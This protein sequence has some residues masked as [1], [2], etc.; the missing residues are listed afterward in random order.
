MSCSVLTVM[1]FLHT[2]RTSVY[3]RHSLAM[4]SV[5]DIS[6]PQVAGIYFVNLVNGLF[7]SIEI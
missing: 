3:N 6:E 5:A 7:S 4:E 1:Q 2:H